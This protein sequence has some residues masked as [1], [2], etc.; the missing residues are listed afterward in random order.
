MLFS[1]LCRRCFS[2]EGQ[3]GI[4]YIAWLRVECDFGVG[5][6]FTLASRHEDSDLFFG[7]TITSG[8]CFFGFPELLTLRKR[9]LDDVGFEVLTVRQVFLRFI[10]ERRQYPVKGLLRTFFGVETACSTASITLATSQPCC[11]AAPVPR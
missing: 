6:G 7:I 9:W 10:F 4:R 2:N 8:S 1:F 5:E 3:I 11:L